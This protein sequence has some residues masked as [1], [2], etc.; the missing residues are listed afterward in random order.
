MKDFHAKDIRNFA[1]VGH[2][3]AGKTTLAEAMLRT[4]GVTQRMGSVVQGN[5]VSDYHEDE[6]S[7]QISVHTSILEMEWEGRKFNMMDS[8]GYPDFIGEPVGA[9]RVSD[10]AMIVVNAQ[11]GV[12]VG[13]E[14]AWQNAD[15]NN[16]PKIV[17][18]NGVDRQEAKYKEVL[19]ELQERFG[20][21]LLPM[22]I[23]L[24]PGPGV[25]RFSDIMRSQ[26]AEYEPNGDGSYTLNMAEDEHEK[27]MAE[28]HQ[29]LIEFVAESDDELLEHFFEAGHLTEDE[30]RASLHSAFQSQSFIPVF[31]V[32]AETNVGTGR[33]LDFIA[34][35]GSSPIDRK[36]IDG[37]HPDGSTVDV[38]L[39]ETSDPALFIFKTMGEEHVGEMSLFRVYSGEVK[40]GM[41]L[42]NANRNAT[43]RIGQIYVINGHDRIPVDHLYA[44]DIGAVVK[45]KNTHTGDTLCDS[46]SPVMLE[47]TK[48]PAPNIHAALV[49]KSRGD[50][51]RVAT[52]LTTLHEEDP[53]FLYRVDRELKQT[54]ISGQGELHMN[55]ITEALQKRFHADVELVQPRIP[56][57][58]T[59]KIP[60]EGKYRH[61][62]QSGGAGQ[63]AEV[64]L[65]IAPNETGA[66]VEFKQSL[67]G[68]NVD[69]VFVPSVEKGVMQAC[70][71]G[72]MTGHMVVDVSVDFFDGKMHP[73]DSKDIAFQIAGKFAFREAFMAAKPVLLEPFLEIEVTVPELYMGDVISDLSSKRGRITGTDVAGRLQVVKATIP[74]SEM[75]YYATRLRSITQ[76]RGIHT[77]QFSHYEAV[78]E[79]LI[80]KIIKEEDAIEEVA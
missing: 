69:R 35:Y 62:K 38:M 41:E 20:S 75:H 11:Y 9:L 13:T 59:V 25:N 74:Q 76:G 55:I 68:Q 23:P 50:E 67:V 15:S 36:R 66:G 53:T 29:A 72:V 56:Y 64:W 33:L 12:E 26:I 32:S 30:L 71:E 77:E 43:E 37:K 17:V 57:R 70:E 39:D 51:E 44:G 28:L 49:S 63:F 34:K 16:I 48:Y 24:N 21:H 80:D 1:I 47:N 65:R 7:R 58:E 42:F 6:I 4:A 46:K 22:D 14:R 18:I 31:S 79:N 27:E 54:I 3:S 10:F 5:T 61:K 2:A 19:D 73:V 8:P 40:T 78:P 45:L 52:G 60:A